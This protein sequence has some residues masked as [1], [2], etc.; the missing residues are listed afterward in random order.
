MKKI[1]NRY[2]ARADMMA[3]IE[4]AEQMISKYGWEDRTVTPWGFE[5]KVTKIIADCKDYDICTKGTQE[6]LVSLANG[7]MPIL[8]A[9]EEHELAPKV[10][11]RQISNG[12]LIKI[13]EC[14]LDMFDGLV[15]L[16]SA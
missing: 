13:R 12:K 10:T 9:W 6:Y 2:T 15:E 4:E 14:D 16:V 8:N 1:E 3:F 11:V 7:L 5:L